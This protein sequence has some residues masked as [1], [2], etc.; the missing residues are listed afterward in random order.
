MPAIATRIIIKTAGFE[1]FG[2]VFP[3]A[4]SFLD[5]EAL[6]VR[7]LDVEEI[8]EEDE[9]WLLVNF[10]EEECDD[11]EADEVVAEG[12]LLLPKGDT[13]VEG[14]WLLDTGEE[15]RIVFELLG[16]VDEGLLVIAELIPPAAFVC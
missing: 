9:L 4:A 11:N 15:D 10:E 1:S 14:F 6:D 5:E 12:L 13:E 8:A 7:L 2:F 3:T 16:I